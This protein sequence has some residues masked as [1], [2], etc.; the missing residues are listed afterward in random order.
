M[1]TNYRDLQAADLYLRRAQEEAA[2]IPT[3]APQ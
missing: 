1:A 2:T 3:G